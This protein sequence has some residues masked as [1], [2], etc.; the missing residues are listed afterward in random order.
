MAVIQEL[1]IYPVKSARGIAQ[2]NVRIGRTGLE[3]DRHWMAIDALGTFI[4]QRTHP[5]LA[6]ITP[7]ITADALVL[8]APDLPPLRLPL[9]ACGESISVK[10]WDDRCT[11]VDQGDEAAEWVSAAVGDVLRLVRQAPCIDRFAKPQFAGP[12]PAHVSFVDGFPVLVCNQASLADLNVRMP[13][14]IPMNRFRPNIVLTGLEPFAEDRIEA[15]QIGAITLRLVKPCTRCVITATDQ[16][17]GERSTNPLPVLRK[18]RF[19]GTLLGVAFG[20]NAVIDAG[21]GLAL[22]R[23]ADCVT[24]AS[25]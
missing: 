15:L 21:F 9:E 13:T 17:T 14:P 25:A 8:T 3:W 1:F 23:G 2:T 11:G 19:D 22:T 5:K 24:L 10:V 18:F 6:R 20:E 4:S 16:I 12:D 7:Q